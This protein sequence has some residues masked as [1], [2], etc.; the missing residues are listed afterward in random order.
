MRIIG[1]GTRKN[2]V[3]V[4]FLRLLA[5]ARGQTHKVNENH[6]ACNFAKIFIDV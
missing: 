3:L 4:H 2:V 1:K 6:V 5:C